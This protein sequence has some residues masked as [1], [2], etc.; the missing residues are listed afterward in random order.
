MQTKIPAFAGTT[1]EGPLPSS[2][3]AGAGF[4]PALAPVG[5]YALI[6]PDAR[7]DTTL[8]SNLPY[9]AVRP[10]SITNSLPVTKE[11]SSEARYRAP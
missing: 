5:Q 1:G 10:P 11:D 7:L 9:I 2:T 4:K 8:V 3:V 6:N